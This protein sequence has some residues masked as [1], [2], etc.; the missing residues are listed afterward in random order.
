ME[1]CTCWSFSYL[2]VVT[3]AL[4]VVTT[5]FK[6]CFVYKAPRWF[7]DYPVCSRVHTLTT[8]VFMENVLTPCRISVKASFRRCHTYNSPSRRLFPN[9]R[10]I[11]SIKNST[12]T[13]SW[14]ERLVHPLSHRKIISR[15]DR[16]AGYSSAFPE[17]SLWDARNRIIVDSR[18]Y[19]WS[20]VLVLVRKGIPSWQCG[21]VL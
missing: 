2:I 1:S 8:V 3:V 17:A 7:S 12:V 16:K 9:S 18:R 11:D 6:M 20:C 14:N 5:N 10:M 21:P 15:P 4:I 13:K 19:W